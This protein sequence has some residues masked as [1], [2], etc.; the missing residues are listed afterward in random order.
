MTMM[1]H[2]SLCEMPYLPFLSECVCVLSHI[3]LIVTPW[4]IVCQA[5]LSTEFSRKKYWS[6]LPF[7]IPGDLPNPGIKPASPALAGRFFTTAPFGK[8]FDDFMIS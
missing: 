8:P 5:P 3:W 4:S 6:S 1:F 2:A 7:P